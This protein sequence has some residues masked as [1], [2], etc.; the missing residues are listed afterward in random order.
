MSEGL[1]GLCRALGFEAPAAEVLDAV[2]QVYREVD[3]ELAEGCHKLELPC[4]S[5]CDD[6]CHESVFVSA[7]EFLAVA[8]ALLGWPAGA[9]AEVVRGMLVLADEFEDEL[10]LLEHLEAGP[11]RDEVA[12]RVKFTCPILS[13]SGRCQVYAV[14]ELNARTF[15]SSLDE[16]TGSPY[17]CEKTHA[18]LQVIPPARLARLAGARAARRRLVQRVPNTAQVHVYPWW[19]ARYREWFTAAKA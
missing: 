4:K 8:E 13:E 10:E 9:R 2:A 16:S 12:A 15:G 19:F 3:A 5:G 11:E 7:P 17:G 18:A 14:R 6:C 1:E